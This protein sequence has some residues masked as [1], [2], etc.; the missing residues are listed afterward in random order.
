[1]AMVVIAFPTKG[2]V[3]AYVYDEN[4]QV[5]CAAGVN[6]AGKMDYAACSNPSCLSG[7]L[8]GEVYNPLSSQASYVAVFRRQ[9]VNP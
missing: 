8:T 5:Y 7:D 6:A 3:D 2:D 1:M 9:F 4:S